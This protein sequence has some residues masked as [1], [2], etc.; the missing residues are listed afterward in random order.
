MYKYFAVLQK[1]TQSRRRQTSLHCRCMANWTKR[2][3]RLWFW[4]VRFIM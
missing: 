2:T 4:P 1:T 3:R